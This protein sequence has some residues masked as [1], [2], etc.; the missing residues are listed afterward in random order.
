MWSILRKRLN[1]C[2]DSRLH[3]AKARRTPLTVRTTLVGLGPGVPSFSAPGNSSRGLLGV[4]TAKISE[5]Y[6]SP[7]G[8]VSI[9]I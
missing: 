3:N 2:E 4:Q 7:T 5:L 8:Q 1:D 6:S 9:K